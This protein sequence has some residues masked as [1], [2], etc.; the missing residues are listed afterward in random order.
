MR[1]SAKT[2]PFSIGI[3]AAALAAAMPA[4]AKE[5]DDL[6]LQ[7]AIGNPDDFTL[8]AASRLRFEALGGQAR[9][10][11]RAS[12]D[13]VS[14]RT[15]VTADYRAAKT[16]RDSGYEVAAGQVLVTNGG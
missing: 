6:T 5:A 11:F 2:W 8:T 12:E 3:A 13:L 1:R 14:L 7:S 10:G 16:L 4:Q 9:A 15:V